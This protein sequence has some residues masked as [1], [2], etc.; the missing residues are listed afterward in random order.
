MSLL[1]TVGMPCFMN[2][3]FYVASILLGDA[4]HEAG[5]L[6]CLLPTAS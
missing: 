6:P 2:S 1:L 5:I 4:Y 3:F